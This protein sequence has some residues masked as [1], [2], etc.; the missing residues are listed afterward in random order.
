MNHPI[1]RSR[2]F[3]KCILKVNQYIVVLHNSSARVEYVFRHRIVKFSLKLLSITKF[4]LPEQAFHR[5]VH[6]REVGLNWD[7][8]N[9]VFR[10]SVHG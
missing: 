3:T 7:V 6:G 10:C 9:K 4:V 8:R 2:S 1:V 5:L